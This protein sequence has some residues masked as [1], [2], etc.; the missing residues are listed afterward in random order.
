MADMKD[1][2]AFTDTY[3]EKISPEFLPEETLKRIAEEIDKPYAEFLR[4]HGIAG[5]D[6]GFIW[7]VNPYEFTEVIA[8]WGLNEKTD[9][10]I[11]RTAFG[12]LFVSSGSGVMVMHVNYNRT[13]PL[14]TSAVY[15]YELILTDRSISGD[16]LF[17]NIYD[18]AL[19]KLGPVK[20]DECYGFV[21]AVPLGGPEDVNNL[22]ITQM[23]PYLEML[24]QAHE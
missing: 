13:T 4:E 23:Y 19:K 8:S 5:Y 21:P 9:H 14:T 1:F 2:Q 18:E 15:L 17:A 3:P 20:H 16:L 24:A 7:S 6:N 12:D 11:A 22:Q 10:V